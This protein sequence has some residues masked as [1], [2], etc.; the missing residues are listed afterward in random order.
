[1]TE[2]VIRLYP[3]APTIA[4][5][6][7]PNCG[8]TALFN[9]L[10]GSRQ[11]V[12][13]YAGVTVER[14]AG[15]L[16][17][18]AGRALRVLDL[19]GTYSLYPRSPDER[20]TVD[21]LAGRAAGERRP[22][23]VVCVV[24]A[25]QL[26]RTLRLV[27]GVLRQGL[28]TVVALNMSDLAERRGQAV[29]AAVLSAGLGVPVVPTIGVRRGGDSALRTLISDPAQWPAAPQAQ[30][31]ASHDEA[32]L[33]TLLRTLGLDAP[34]EDRVTELIDRAVLH[35]LLGPILLAAVLGLSFQAVFS[36]AETPMAAIG[37]AINALGAGLRE[38]LPTQGHGAWLSSLLIDGVLAGAGSVLVFLPQILIL[39][40][41]IL[42]L[43]ESGYLPRAAFLL[44]RWMGQVGLSG[45]AFLP[46]LS[47]FACAVP[48]IL[49]TRTIP[50]ARDRWVTLLIT[51]LMTCSARLPVYTLLIA[52]FVPAVTVG[53]TPLQLQGLVLL[54][55]YATGVGSAFGVAW[56]LKWLRRTETPRVLMM[57]LPAYRWPAPRH[58]ALGLLNRARIFLTRV[59]G[60]ILVCNL[61]LWL[62][63]SIPA[64]GQS[65]GGIEHS[66]AGV[67]GRW[68]AVVL[69]PVGLNWQIALA[70]VPGLAAREL[71][72]AALG[73][74]YALGTDPVAGALVPIIQQGWTAATGFALLAWFVFAPQCVSTLAAVRRESGSWVLPALITVYLFGLAWLAAGLT[75][76]VALAL[77]AG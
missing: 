35:P 64:P 39:F 50:D 66:L 2:A 57:E 60:V 14:K 51:P 20:V 10:T 26:H 5:V 3:S 55:L 29:D 65:G 8:K 52:A 21:V 77:G 73:T 32:R 30:A 12:A 18:S 47:S 31:D 49:A 67:I 58:L 68:L 28:P 59:G 48:G 76:R 24:D 53:N 4:L 36:W 17:G 44:D 56:L 45:R 74:V 70:L 54:A 7:N 6:G 41:F 9:L 63:A 1:M 42:V 34:G 72:V 33:H 75:Y 46:L 16:M 15:Q 71:V 11:K 37:A 40:G 13:N 27:L 22:D 23:L 69:E 19:P 43:E 38:T 61:I 62:L 25:T